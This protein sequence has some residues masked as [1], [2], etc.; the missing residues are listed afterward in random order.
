M[1]DVWKLV[2]AERAALLADLRDLPD[3]R[4]DTPSL[5]PGWTVH[6]VLAHL[7]DTARTTRTRFVLGMLRARMD[8]DRPQNAAGVARER[9]ATPA[10]TVRRFAAC[11]P[12]TA[13]PPAPLATRWVEMVVHGE[14][15]RRP[16]GIV[17]PYAPAAVAGAVQVQA[18]TSV[19]F[20]GARET[21][22]GLCLRRDRRRP[23]DRV[24]HGGDRDGAGPAPRGLGEAGPAGGARGAR[25][26]RARAG[27]VISACLR[28]WSE[29]TDHSRL[30]CGRPL[31]A[32]TVG[33]HPH[34]RSWR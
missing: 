17:R 4:W 8:F 34:T 24:R 20:G 33:T 25:R 3:D 1:T 32:A 29:A 27:G 6:D 11:L 12:L 28:P 22:S 15:I 21:V 16:L 14:D 10:E 23:R 2:H 9:G 18:R 26:G 7:V 30:R 13:T 5:C 19:S 31:S